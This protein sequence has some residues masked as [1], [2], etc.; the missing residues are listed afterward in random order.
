MNTKEEKRTIRKIKRRLNKFVNIDGFYG[1]ICGY[2]IS[3]DL[4]LLTISQFDEKRIALEACES[5]NVLNN[6]KNNFGAST[7]KLISKP[8]FY[9]YALPLYGIF[10]R[11]KIVK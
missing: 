2:D 11:I 4:I 3:N 7:Y 5:G 10:R 1:Y 9:I 8:K 6:I